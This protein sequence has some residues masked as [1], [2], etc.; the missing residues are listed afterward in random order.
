M[1]PA[2]CLQ[3]WWQCWWWCWFVCWPVGKRWEIGLQRFRREKWSR[4]KKQKSN[5]KKKNVS[6]AKMIF[7]KSFSLSLSHSL[8][9]SLSLSHFLSLTLTLSFSL[10]LSLL[11]SFSSP[12]LSHSHT[13]SVTN[14]SLAVDWNYFFHKKCFV[15]RVAISYL[16]FDTRN[17]YL[18]S[19]LKVFF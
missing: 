11:H 10:S 1:Y 7:P 9:L 3:L 19:N 6:L 8:S 14:G 5:Q 12:S 17:F 16:K 2:K 18:H 15:D 4:Q 13:L